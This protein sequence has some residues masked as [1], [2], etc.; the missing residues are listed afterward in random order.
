MNMMYFFSVT[1]YSG[2]L[3]IIRPG[4][5]IN[6]EKDIYPNAVVG[7]IKESLSR[8]LCNKQLLHRIVQAS[9]VVPETT[10]IPASKQLIIF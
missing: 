5:F 8:F 1:S 10:G 3:F 4:G 7:G 2:N 6:F 9:L